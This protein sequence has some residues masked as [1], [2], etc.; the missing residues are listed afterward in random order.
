M[1]KLT[2][3]LKTEEIEKF[4]EITDKVYEIGLKNGRVEMKN[5][6]LKKI[7]RDFS[8]VTFCKPRE[9]VMKIMKLIDKIK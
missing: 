1:K 3:D 2:L 6:I 7:N 5:K 8:L 4:K 9:A